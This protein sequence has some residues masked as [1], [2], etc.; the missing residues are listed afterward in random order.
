MGRE[1]L[2]YIIASLCLG[3]IAVWASEALFWSAPPADLDPVGL[4]LTYAAYSVVCACVLS[5]VAWSGCGGWT[6]LFL[7]G[8]LLGWLT[9]GV[10]VGTMYDVFP[11]QMVW[12]PLA[13]HALITAVLVFGLCRIAVRRRVISQIGMMLGIGLLGGTWAAFW[14]VERADLPGT[15]AALWYLVGT[16]ILVPPALILLDRIATVPKPTAW[17]R[18]VAPMVAFAV[19]LVSSAFA[20]APQRLAL[21]MV[22]VLT[23]WAMRRLGQTQSPS[24]FGR[25]ADN[26]RRHWLFLIAPTVTALIAGQVW[27][28]GG[29]AVNVPF[30][31]IT[32]SVSLIWWV[33]LLVKAYRRKAISA[34][35]KSIAPS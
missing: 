20:P 16:G 33:W 5:A 11:F 30:A 13:W 26:P 22:L 1:T 8:A 24:D 18:A 28:L 14:P 15:A 35:A 10:V 4:A 9:E 32:G 27:P 25:R 3:V 7:G 12:T 21:P 17:V 2:H 29:I 23:L 34:D 19:W 6:G 31:L